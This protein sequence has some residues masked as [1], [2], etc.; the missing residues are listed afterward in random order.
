MD[1]QD[2]IDMKLGILPDEKYEA[3]YMISPRQIKA[4]EERF[5]T[6][7]HPVNVYSNI[8]EGFEY[9]MCPFGAKGEYGQKAS[10][11]AP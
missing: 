6:C 7:E 4:Y 2:W 9:C 8:G 10:S 11:D 5:T 1:S 3:Y